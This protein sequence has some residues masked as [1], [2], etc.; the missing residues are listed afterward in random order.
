MRTGCVVA[1]ILA[2]ARVAVAQPSATPSAPETQPP[3][4]TASPPAGPPLTLD[5][6]IQLAMTR[7]ER[8]RI[9]E[10]DLVVSDAAVE[11][12]RTN[13]LPVLSASG[14]DTLH[15]DAPHNT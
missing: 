7:N 3:A 14:N 2:T 5:Q 13:F 15:R 10:L 11:K 8:A 6:A 12:A 1:A 9:A 4:T